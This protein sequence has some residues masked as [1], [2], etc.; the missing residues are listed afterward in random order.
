MKQQLELN[1][2]PPEGKPTNW[3]IPLLI[4]LV[5][6]A[7][8]LTVVF[9]SVFDEMKTTLILKIVGPILVMLGLTFT[10]LRIL[11]TRVP[12]SFVKIRLKKKRATFHVESRNNDESANHAADEMKNANLEQKDKTLTDGRNINNGNIENKRHY[13]QV[14]AQK[15][16]ILL[17]VSKLE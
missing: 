4:S 15:A 14:K 3:N 9:L 16:E 11:F 1:K 13:R 12:T 6:L 5:G 10:L 2:P 17:K 7:A 8:G